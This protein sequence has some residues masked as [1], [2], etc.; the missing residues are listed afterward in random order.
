M[1]DETLPENPETWV[2]QIT[3]TY[4][5]EIV[6]IGLGENGT[7]MS[8]RGDHF[9]ERIPAVKT[10]PVVNTIGAGDELF[11]AFLHSFAYSGDPYEAVRKVVFFASYK[12]RDKVAADGFLGNE[13]LELLYKNHEI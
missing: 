5:T 13:E 6:V 4:G 1:G 2:K 7:L 12:I 11:S 3:S 9:L 10:R 8:V